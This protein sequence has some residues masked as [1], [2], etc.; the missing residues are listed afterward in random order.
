MHVVQDRP[1]VIERGEGA[2]VFDSGG[3]KYLDAT[4]G[5]WFANLGYG[6]RDIAD[7]VHDQMERLF[8]Y[9]TFTDFAT[10]PALA[11]AEKIAARSPN[12]ASKVFFTS[13]GSDAVDSGA[14]LIR[15]YHNLTGAPERT[16]I[17]AREWAYHGTHAYGTSL[18]GI[19]P[20]ATGY[21]NLVGDV[22]LV[23][24]DDV[25]AV[26]KAIDH[27][28]AERIGGMFCE[29]VIGAGGVRPVSVDYLVAVRDLIRAA[30]GLFVSDEVITGFGR[31]GDWFAANRFDLDP[32]LILF[33]KGVTAGYQPLG[34][35][36]AS[37]R[38]AAPFFDQPGIVWRHGYTYS[39]HATACVAGLEV[40]RIYEEEGIFARAM[41]LET[42]LD[43]SLHAL[44]GTGPAISVR[45]GTGAM[46]AVQLDPGDSTLAARVALATRSAGVITRAI[47][48]NGLQISPPLIFTSSQVEEMVEG[49]RTGL[50]AM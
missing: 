36:I 20:N 21:G 23:P 34:G 19:E 1:F 2:Y 50:L 33:A 45:A 25:D 30:G 5:L 14:K 6:R 28:G 10:P 47:A 44:I 29:P 38:I 11:L 18:A 31:V 22:V 3:R 40:M 27:T 8:A 16:V 32:D 12:P 13:G 48:G 43:L 39:G 35:V 4:A 9:H 46:A 7:A 24:H 26:E 37:P 17:I 41:E 49:L 15:R 42:E